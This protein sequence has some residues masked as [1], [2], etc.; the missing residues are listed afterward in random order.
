M[1]AI[2]INYRGSVRVK[3]NRQMIL[4]VNGIDSKDK[5]AKLVGKKVVFT[6]PGKK[7]MVGVISAPHGNNGALRAKWETGMP[8]QAIGSK[9]KI[10]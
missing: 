6:T 7:Q 3:N 10:E 8:G 1:E 4:E 2:V 5:A 9:V